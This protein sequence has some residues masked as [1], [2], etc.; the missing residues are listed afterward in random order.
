MRPPSL[1][2]WYRSRS[3][4]RG[5][6]RWPP[7]WLLAVPPFCVRADQPVSQ[8]PG[9]R[10]WRHG[11]ADRFRACQR[12]IM[13]L[14]IGIAETNHE[15]RCQRHAMLAPWRLDLSGNHLVIQTGLTREYKRTDLFPRIGESALPSSDQQHPLASSSNSG[16]AACSSVSGLLGSRQSL[17]PDDTSIESKMNYRTRH[18]ST[19][20]LGPVYQKR[21][22]YEKPPAPKPSPKPSPDQG[23]K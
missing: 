16:V 21:G 19:P 1:A 14:G 6:K 4:D 12:S 8:S 10:D 15:S 2:S 20:G 7:T 3:P 13:I 22:A 9:R 23:S 18:A 11:L 17:S 5:G